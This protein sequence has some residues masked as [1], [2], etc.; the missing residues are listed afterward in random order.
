[1][2]A[3]IIE[4]SPLPLG[5]PPGI[6]TV[7]LMSHTTSQRG[8]PVCWCPEE[9]QARLGSPKVEWDWLKAFRY[10]KT[11]YMEVQEGRHFHLL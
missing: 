7:L 4:H 11:R 2:S 3:N 8:E 6:N 9:R 5:L 10:L 1:M